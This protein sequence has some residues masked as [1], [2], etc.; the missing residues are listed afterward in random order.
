[1]VAHGHGYL[2]RVSSGIAGA[3]WEQALRRADGQAQAV[4]IGSTPV[5]PSRF[6]GL[7]VTARRGRRALR[8]ACKARLGSRA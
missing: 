7:C 5:A 1:M 3:I 8:G 6:Y 4:G 2:H